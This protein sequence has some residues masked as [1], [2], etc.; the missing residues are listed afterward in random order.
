MRCKEIETKANYKEVDAMMLIKR[1]GL[2]IIT[3]STIFICN[4]SET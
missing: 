3:V 2:L 4:K 1:G